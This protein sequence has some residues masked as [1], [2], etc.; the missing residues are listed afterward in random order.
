MLQR[1]T[2][3]LRVRDRVPAGSDRA[4]ERRR[5]RRAVEVL[6]EPRHRRCRVRWDDGQRILLHP[7]AGV[8]LEG[9]ALE[10]E[11]RR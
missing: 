7:G 9:R 1:E 5:S 2:R 6:R 8:R 3:E 10:K 4:G 11:E